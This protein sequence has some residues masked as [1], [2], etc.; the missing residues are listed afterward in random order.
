MGGNKY[1]HEYI[2][3]FKN[4]LRDNVRDNVNESVVKY[5]EFNEVVDTDPKKVEK[6]YWNPWTPI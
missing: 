4:R 6:K 3:E 2:E 5:A 1:S